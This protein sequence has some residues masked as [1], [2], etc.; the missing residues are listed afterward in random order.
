MKKPRTFND[1]KKARVFCTRVNGQIQHRKARKGN[2]FYSCWIV[3]Y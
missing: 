1:Y 3:W 2:M